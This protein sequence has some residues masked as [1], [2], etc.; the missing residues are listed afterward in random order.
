M[1]FG[2]LICFYDCVS[3]LM[4]RVIFLSVLGLLCRLVWVRCSML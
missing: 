4:S 2:F 1:G 3:G